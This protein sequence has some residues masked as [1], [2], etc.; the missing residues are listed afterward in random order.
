MNLLP[1]YCQEE[2]SGNSTN[3]VV[4]CIA[5]FLRPLPE[6]SCPMAFVMQDGCQ[7]DWAFFR[8]NIFYVTGDTKQYISI[9]REVIILSTKSLIYWLKKNNTFN[10]KWATSAIEDQKSKSFL[11]TDLFIT[12][13]MLVMIKSSESCKCFREEPSMEII[14]FLYGNPLNIRMACLFK[15]LWI[16]LR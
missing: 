2:C 12:V 5:C 8:R 4:R 10:R 11:I 1:C 3:K 15:S 13:T 7:Q 14:G 6:S 9:G 16:F